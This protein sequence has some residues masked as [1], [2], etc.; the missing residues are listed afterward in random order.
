[1]KHERDKSDDVGLEIDP[2]GD[3]GDAGVLEGSSGAEGLISFVTRPSRWR[4][5]RLF[6]SPPGAPVARRPTDVVLFVGAL[7]TI[8]ILTVTLGAAPVGFEAALADVQASFPEFLE[9]VWQIGY[10][11]LAFWAIAVVIAVTVRRRW[12][13]LLHVLTAFVTTVLVGAFL[14]W[15]VESD[16]PSVRQLVN[17]GWPADH[18]PLAAP[19]VPGQRRRLR[20]H[21][22]AA[23]RARGV[24]HPPRRAQ[25]RSGHTDR[26]RGAG[27]RR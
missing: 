1:M 2:D 24:P 13:L 14:W 20:P 21:S 11:L 10:D 27:R 12:S 9:P 25:G 5:L 3:R 19:M 16:W 26:G 6:A 4:E 22:A 15:V 18:H 23:S 17:V 8:L 7:F